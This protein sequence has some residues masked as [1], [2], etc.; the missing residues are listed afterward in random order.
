MLCRCAAIGSPNALSLP[1][2]LQTLDMILN[3]F[4]FP[5]CR[6]AIDQQ[7]RCMSTQQIAV[8]AH[9]AE[10]VVRCLERDKH[11]LLQRHTPE[12]MLLRSLQKHQ[13]AVLLCDAA[14]TGWPVLFTNKSCHDMLGWGAGTLGGRGVW[15]VFNLSALAKVHN[16]YNVHVCAVDI[17][18]PCA[19]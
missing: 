10:M 18:C 6:C 15:E 8:L 9:L 13:E 7:P 3:A 17:T 11:A 1:S 4:W 12:T 5:P 2:Y 14:M 19:T 16:I